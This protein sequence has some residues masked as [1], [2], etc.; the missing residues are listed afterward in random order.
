LGR[1]PGVLNYPLTMDK[2]DKWAG[3]THG[4]ITYSKSHPE[5][6]AKARWIEEVTAKT[7]NDL[8]ALAKAKA[9][10]YV[11]I[12]ESN[13]ITFREYMQVTGSLGLAMVVVA[14]SD[15]GQDTSR[16]PKVNPAN[17]AF[18]KANRAKLDTLQDEYWELAKYRGQ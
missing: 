10:Q 14:M 17:V 7:L 13:G 11:A 15:A 2:I 6:L 12:V 9:G 8:V 4:V 18:V 16:L 5:I 1:Y 3:A